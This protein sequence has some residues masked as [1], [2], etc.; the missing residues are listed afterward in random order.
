[1][2]VHKRSRQLHGWLAALMLALLA[3]ALAGC[4]DGKETAEGEAAPSRAI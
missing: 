4:G 2:R 1:M 3:L